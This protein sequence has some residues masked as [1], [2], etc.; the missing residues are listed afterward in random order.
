M[1][2]HFHAAIEHW[3]ARDYLADGQLVYISMQWTTS[4]FSVLSAIGK[5][6]EGELTEL[7]EQEKEK[8]TK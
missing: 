7:I 1:N 4:L 5:F 3:D 8:N 2:F 6:S